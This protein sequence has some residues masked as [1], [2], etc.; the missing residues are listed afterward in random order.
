[1]TTTKERE[2][3]QQALEALDVLLTEP[4]AKI[5][6]DKAEALLLRAAPALRKALSKPVKQSISEEAF[7]W[8]D[9]N[10]PMFVREALAGDNMTPTEQAELNLNC[11]SVQARLATSWGYVKAEQAEQEPVAWRWKNGN[12]WLNKYTYLDNGAPDCPEL[13][14]PL[15]AA[16]VRTKDLTELLDVMVGMANYID[17]LGGDSKG[18]RAVIAADREKN[19]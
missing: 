14:E 9:A 5:A 12:E 11:K 10:A 7:N 13:C 15:Y 8:I 17:K 18:F 1:M 16:P 2:A 4:M 6:A 19:K 3:M